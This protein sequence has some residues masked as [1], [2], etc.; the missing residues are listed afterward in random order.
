MS[1]EEKE[2]IKKKM[3]DAADEAANQIPQLKD[4]Q[5]VAKWYKSNYMAAGY[6]N[7]THRLWKYFGL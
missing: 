3:N 2:A 5:D 1:D 4:A 7:L 6:K